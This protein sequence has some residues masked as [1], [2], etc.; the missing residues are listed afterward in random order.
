MPNKG[1]RKP[2]D[3]KLKL[4]LFRLEIRFQIGSV[5]NLWNNFPRGVM[6]PP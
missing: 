2:N 4:D 6:D 3:W 1:R 5:A